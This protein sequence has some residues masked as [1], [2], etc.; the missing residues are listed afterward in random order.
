MSI[1]SVGTIGFGNQGSNPDYVVV[2]SNN[3]E[4]LKALQEAE[5]QSKGAIIQN[6]VSNATNRGQLDPHGFPIK[7]NTQ[8]VIDSSAAIG[9]EAFK[10]SNSERISR[11]NSDMI[12]FHNKKPF[13]K[14]WSSK[15][16][17]LIYKTLP[18]TLIR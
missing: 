4:V 15:R 9:D 1:N 13:R 5:R 10:R 17:G 2:R 14:P 18:F 12:I 7:G 3:G 8:Q 11:R 6:Y 16:V